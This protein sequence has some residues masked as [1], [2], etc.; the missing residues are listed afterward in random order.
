M[1]PIEL[2]HFKD[3]LAERA[4]SITSWLDSESFRDD[5]DVRKVYSLLSQIK[6][7]VVRIES[8]TYGICEDCHDPIEQ[9][10]LEIQPA[11]TVCLGCMNDQERMQLEEELS[12]A[13]KIHRA[14][15]PQTIEQIDGFEVVVKSIAAR[16]VGGDYYDFLPAGDSGMPRVVIADVMGKGLPAGL[17][18]S[19]VQGVL[20]ILAEELQSPRELIVRLNQWYC[21]NVPVTK[22]VSMACLSLR[23]LPDGKAELVYAN[24]GHCP[25]I[26]LRNNGATEIL[27]PTGGVLGVHK[28]FTYEERR[29]QISSGDLVL[30]YTDGVTEVEDEGGQQFGEER[31][32]SLIYNYRGASIAEFPDVLLNEVQRF[33]GKAELTDD[34]TIIGLRKI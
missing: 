8:K 12:M 16:T 24:A 6:E 29:T 27:E 31:L 33:S 18:M 10:Y 13:S 20:R 34:L 15:L 14:L 2:E 26:L 28:D 7:A 3:L 23:S 30:L 21:R 25:P 32:N 11:A 9:Y 22:F 19:N 1:T 17:L 5:D 4:D